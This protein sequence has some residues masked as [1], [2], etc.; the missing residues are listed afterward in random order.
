MSTWWPRR[1]PWP[2]ARRWHSWAWTR[3]IR[4]RRMAWRS[5][6]ASMPRRWTMPARRGRRRGASPVAIWRRDPACA[7]TPMP[8]TAWRRRPT[9]TACWPSWWCTTPAAMPRRCAGRSA[10]W[11]NAGWTAWQPTCRCCARW[12]RMTTWPTTA[13]TPAGWKPPG[14]ICKASWLPTPMR[15]RTSHLP[16]WH[17]TRP[18]PPCPTVRSPCAPRWPAAWSSSTPPLARRWPPAV[19]HWCWRR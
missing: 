5:S 19:R 13:S 9:T 4:P 1:S 10:R 14:R 8:S 6:G 17:P 18:R 11:L 15:R 12:P 16:P 3:R 2:P 7:S